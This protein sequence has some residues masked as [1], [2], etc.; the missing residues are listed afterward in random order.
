MGNH[1]EA[2]VDF[3]KVIELNPSFDVYLMRGNSFN[4]L[5][6]YEKASSDYSKSIELNPQNH[7][8]YK[9]IGDLYFVLNQ[10]EK[11]CENWKKAVALGSKEAKEKIKKYCK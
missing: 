3:S 9:T 8:A 11:A 2:I 6:K 5:K 7:E 10:A 4:Q 1:E